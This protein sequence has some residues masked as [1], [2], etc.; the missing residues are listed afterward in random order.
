MLDTTAHEGVESALVGVSFGQV[1]KPIGGVSKRPTAQT[2]GHVAPIGGLPFRADVSTPEAGL[3]S[4]YAHRIGAH[5]EVD[6]HR[7]PA[8][9]PRP[10]GNAEAA[11]NRGAASAEASPE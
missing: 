2:L 9:R 4:L 8:A 7:R 10:H 3:A 1:R 5:R 6:G 11:R